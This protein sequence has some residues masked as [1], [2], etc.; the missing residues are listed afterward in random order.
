MQI[1]E[2]FKQLKLAIP[3]SLFVVLMVLNYAC[4]STPEEYCQEAE[5]IC[6]EVVIACSS[7]DEEY[8]VLSGDTIYCAAVDNCAAAEDSLISVCTVM[9]S[10]N[11]QLEARQKL[12]AIMESVRAMT[13]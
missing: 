4:E 12:V 11:A 8:Y 13:L 3:S 2:R 7:S 1:N 9:K 10:T 5:D 6:E